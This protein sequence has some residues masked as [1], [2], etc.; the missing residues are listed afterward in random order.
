MSRSSFWSSSEM[1]RQVGDLGSTVRPADWRMP[2]TD[3]IPPLAGGGIQY[4]ALK[5]FFFLDRDRAVT[6]LKRVVHADHLAPL[7]LSLVH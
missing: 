3:S 5:G 7:G 2:D 1:A 4:F 6:D